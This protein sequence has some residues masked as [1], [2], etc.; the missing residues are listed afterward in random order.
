MA[1]LRA[2]EL[3]RR[4]RIDGKSITHSDSGEE[5]VTW[6]E[7]DTVYAKKVEAR[8]AERFAAQQYVGHAIKTFRIRWSEI[9]AVVTTEHRLVFDGRNHDITDVR[10]IGRREGIEIDCYI[11]SEEPVAS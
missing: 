6:V 4:I 8:G 7:V 1:G 10:E 3:D 2:G 9:V 11:P 5:I